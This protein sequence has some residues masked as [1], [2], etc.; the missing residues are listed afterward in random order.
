MSIKTVD[1]QTI[2]QICFVAVGT[3]REAVSEDEVE[4]KT[5]EELPAEEQGKITDYCVAVLSGR[6]TPDTYEGRMIARICHQF[7]D[8]KKTLKYA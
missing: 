1:L 7:M 6:Q 8:P 5:W 2:A 3:L 4:A